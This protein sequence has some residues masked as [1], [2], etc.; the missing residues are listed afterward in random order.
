MYNVVYFEISGRCNARCPWCTT[1][2]KILQGRETGTD[3]KPERFR[4]GVQYL[5]QNGFVND[6]SII[7][8]FSW[9]E[10]YLNPDFKEIVDILNEEN[11]PWGL[12]TN[13][14]VRTFFD[15]PGVMR[16]LKQIII[17]M[18]G[19]SQRAYDKC[20]GFNFEKIKQNIVDLV[21]N[22][23]QMGFAG[24]VSLSYHLYQFNM[25]DAQLLF[26]FC[27]QH[28]FKI[29][30]SL[31]YIADWEEYRKYLIGEMDRDRLK[32]ASQS[33]FLSHIDL[34]LEELKKLDACQCP[35]YNVLTIDED[36]KVV[37]CCLVDKDHPDYSI[38]SLFNLSVD[39]IKEKK[40]AQSICKECHDLGIWYLVQSPVSPISAFTIQ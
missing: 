1:G 22:Y 11:M 36:C 25:N 19:F 4:E 7:K 38:G 34:K 21:Q 33:L 12:S 23:R 10:P 17:S 20:H 6:G 28:G 40:R 9:G 30:A 31:A 16:N 24:E 14:S 2:R 8:L 13:A 37:T 39:E 26:A 35:Q 3:I 29:S 5:K 32:L 27:Q 18:P 15:K